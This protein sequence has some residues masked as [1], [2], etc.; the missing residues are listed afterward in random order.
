M[1]NVNLSE[2]PVNLLHYSDALSADWSRASSVQY[3]SRRLSGSMVNSLTMTNPITI[4]RD[5]PIVSSERKAYKYYVTIL[6]T[7]IVV[8]TRPD[9]ARVKED[10]MRNALYERYEEMRIAEMQAAHQRARE[11]MQRYQAATGAIS[12]ARGTM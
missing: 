3:Y 5:L 8:N 2:V 6:G 9:S 4:K 7:G 10:T 12:W 11:D 1:P